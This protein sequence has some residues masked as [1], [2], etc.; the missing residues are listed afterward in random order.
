MNASSRK[1]KLTPELS[2]P[3]SANKSLKP[4]NKLFKRESSS[5]ASLSLQNS[6]KQSKM[7]LRNTFWEFWLKIL[8]TNNA[9]IQSGTKI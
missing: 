3:K 1:V 8:K 7:T 6:S 9:T 2:I 4:Q 5:I